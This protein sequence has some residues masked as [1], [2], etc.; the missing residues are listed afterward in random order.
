MLH[1]AYVQSF[2]NTASLLSRSGVAFTHS[3]LIGNSLVHDA[4]NRLISDFLH[5]EEATDLLFIDAD[6]GWEPEAA[7]RLIQSPH[8]VIGGAYPQK[9]EW[10]GGPLF[11]VGLKKGAT[12]TNSL[13]EGDFLGAGFPTELGRGCV[14]ERVGKEV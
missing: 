14:R 6:I 4:R 7:L 9:R 3:F 13:L 2:M 12:Q 5:R 11:N 10:P 8:D 1:V